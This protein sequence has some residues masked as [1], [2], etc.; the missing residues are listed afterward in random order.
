LITQL[1]TEKNSLLKSV[2]NFNVGKPIDPLALRVLAFVSY[3]QLCTNRLT[4]VISD[5]AKAVTAEKPAQ[6]IEA[7]Q[8][9]SRL[10]IAKQL[11]LRDNTGN[12]IELGQPMLDLLA[13]GKEATPLEITERELWRRWRKAD[14]DAAKRKA[15]DSFENLPTA[16]QL[17]TKLGESVIGLD[18]QVR[19]FAHLLDHTINQ[20]DILHRNGML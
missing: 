3:L 20:L 4:I 17:A 7:R 5:V 6:M 19:T 1:S 10:L 8:A 11:V 9:V 18:E 13:G 2:F 16:K 14:A 15:K 12:C